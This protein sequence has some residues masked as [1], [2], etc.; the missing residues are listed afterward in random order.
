VAD[1]RKTG[2]ITDVQAA[3]IEAGQIRQGRNEGGNRS[4]AN[5]VN[6][7]RDRF[8]IRFKIKIIYIL[9]F[10]KKTSNLIYTNNLCAIV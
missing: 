2:K 9:E 6:R 4:M 1:L 5:K 8:K 10:G 3:K 7:N